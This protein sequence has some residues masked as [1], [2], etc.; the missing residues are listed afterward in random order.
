MT[1]VVLVHGAWHGAWSFDRVVP[2]VREA[3]IDVVTVDL[4]GHG[5]DEGPFTD[6]HGDADRVIRVL[7]AIDDDVVLL[8]H[9]YGGA[10]ITD[11]GVHPR[12]RHL[13]Y[14]CAFPLAEGETCQSAATDE[15][16]A[17]NI[18]HDGRPNVAESIV[19]ADDGTS[20]VTPA[21][22]V[23][24]LYQDCDDE[25]RAWAVA[26]VGPQ[27]MAALGQSPRAVAWRTT[28]STYVVCTEDMM[29]HPELQHLLAARCTNW[30]DWPT[31]HSPFASRPDLVADLLVDL[32]G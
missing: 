25:T 32:A 19:F 18:A 17:V 14:L 11:A 23:A 29:V 31:S 4:P 8:G 7:D 30:V 1:T 10:V 5:E 16:V 6:L 24:C 21:G 12:V 13:V 28:P 9:S 22:V 15:A 20:T 27:P 3:G 2:L 26:H